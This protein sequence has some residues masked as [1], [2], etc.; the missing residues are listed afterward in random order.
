ME[1]GMHPDIKNVVQ[2]ENGPRFVLE[3][4]YQGAHLTV[5]TGYDVTHDEWLL[6]VYINL[7]GGRQVRVSKQPTHLRAD[8]VQAAFD[9][10]MNIAVRHLSQPEDSFTK[11]INEALRKS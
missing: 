4:D 7:D 11:E 3:G 10:G 9:H 8:S 1:T 6:H 2:T 5:A